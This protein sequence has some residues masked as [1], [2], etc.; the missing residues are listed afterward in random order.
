MLGDSMEML[1][2]GKGF[3]NKMSFGRAGLDKALGEVLKNNYLHED[4]L[5]RKRFLKRGV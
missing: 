5:G 4:S 3:S 2:E 1:L